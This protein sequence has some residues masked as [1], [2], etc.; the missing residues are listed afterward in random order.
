MSSGLLD[1]LEKG[2]NERDYSDYWLANVENTVPGIVIQ[3]RR[4]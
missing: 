4:T 3:V 2:C 1:P